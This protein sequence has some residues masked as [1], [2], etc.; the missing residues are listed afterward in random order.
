MNSL[1]RRETIADI[2]K[3]MAHPARLAIIE[4]LAEK[5][6]CVCELK[7][8][9][10]SDMSM[11]SKHLSVLKSAG[12]VSDRKDGLQVFYSLKT[13]CVVNFIGCLEK[14]VRKQAQEQLTLMA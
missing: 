5:S 10:G 6:Y 3:A 2:F 13:P 14:M 1:S 9:V 11:V 12:L 4:A 8:M 7:E